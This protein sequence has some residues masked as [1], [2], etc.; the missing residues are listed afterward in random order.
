M[1]LNLKPVGVTNVT[2]IIPE[3]KDSKGNPIG[4]YVMFA[5]PGQG[6]S[7]AIKCLVKKNGR[8][9][10]NI[11]AFTST[12]TFNGDYDYLPKNC[13]KD[14]FTDEMLKKIMGFQMKNKKNHMLLII[15]DMIGSINFKSKLWKKF[16]MSYRH[17]RV[18]CIFTTQYPKELPPLFRNCV[19]NAYVFHTTD[20]VAL[21][22]LRE[23]F[24]GDMTTRE[25][26]YF[27]KKNTGDYKYVHVVPHPPV[28]SGIEKY[29]FN[30]MPA[31]GNF[32]IKF[33]R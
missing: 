32:K 3:I 15:D 21:E 1:S 24:F 13:I 5:P 26:S 23:L 20:L 30:K 6:K 27:M 31:V 19:S 22:A 2:N 8:K 17:Y 18:C 25:L 16:V 7:Y 4:L 10:N 11:Y 9:F 14:E 29:T 33:K 28:G 12:G